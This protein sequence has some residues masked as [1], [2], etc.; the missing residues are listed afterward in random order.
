M[1]Y[2]LCADELAS[3]LAEDA[4]PLTVE[5]IKAIDDRLKELKPLVLRQTPAM[6]IAIRDGR[7]RRVSWSP[8]RRWLSARWSDTLIMGLR[9][10]Y[11][12]TTL[13]KGVKTWG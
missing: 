11:W 1:A 6:F 5:E 7:L 8:L 12:L 13:A 9:F 2:Q 3:L 4:T 10:R